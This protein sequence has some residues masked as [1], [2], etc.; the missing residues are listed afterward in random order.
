MLRRH[1]AEDV[2]L[3]ALPARA[4]KESDVPRERPRILHLLDWTI[5][6]K[7][8]FRGAPLGR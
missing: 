8:P 7:L 4:G 6:V 2:H 3:H 1:S 5:P